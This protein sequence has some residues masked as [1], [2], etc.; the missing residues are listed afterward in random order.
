MQCLSL[1]HLLFVLAILLQKYGQDICKTMSLEFNGKKTSKMFAKQCTHDISAKTR[2]PDVCRTVLVNV[3]IQERLA[4][5][6]VRAHKLV[7]VLTPG[8]NYEWL[9]KPDSLPNSK[10]FSELR[11]RGVAII[12][13]NSFYFIFL[14][15]RNYVKF[16]PELKCQRHYSAHPKL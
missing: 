10:Y 14:S 9:G 6:S 1:G 5:T 3:D 15:R 11:Y 8:D 12:R 2:E 7:N 16:A 13:E 4:C